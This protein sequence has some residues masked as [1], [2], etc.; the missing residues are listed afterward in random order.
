MKVSIGVQFLFAA[1]K[2][3]S[4]SEERRICSH[5]KNVI[6]N[7]RLRNCSYVGAMVGF[8]GRM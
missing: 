5:K 7:R 2:D 1:Q 4:D 6:L 3:D 8:G